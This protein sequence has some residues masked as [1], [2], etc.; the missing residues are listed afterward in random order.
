MTFFT[1]EQYVRY[2]VS[3]FPTLFAGKSYD[4]VFFRVMDQL[5]NV[6]GNG[7][8]DTQELFKNLTFREFDPNEADKFMRGETV[9]YGYADV[10]DC[11]PFVRPSMSCKPIY[12]AESDKSLYPDIK[13]WMESTYY[14]KDPYPNFEKEYSIVHRSKF[15]QLGHEWLEAAIR[16]Y[17]MCLD[18]FNSPN[19]NRYLYAFPGENDKETSR[20]LDDFERALAKYSTHEDI[21]EAYGVEYTGDLE[22]FLR[23][24]WAEELARIN[25]YLKDTINMLTSWSNK[26]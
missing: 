15:K 17:T 19:A 20:I 13:L 6:N 9:W 14:E 10:V 26:L 18:F 16:F 23:R 11:G 8:R 4:D 1:P 2:Q 12:V 22:D 21:S 25:S 7:I 24:K 3:K 5:L